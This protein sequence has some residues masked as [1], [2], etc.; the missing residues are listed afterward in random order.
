MP[1]VLYDSLNRRRRDVAVSTGR[2]VNPQRP[3]VLTWLEEIQRLGPSSRFYLTEYT[4]RPDVKDVH[5]RRTLSHLNHET[6]TGYGGA[7]LDRPSAF[8]T[9]CYALT[10]EAIYDINDASERLLKGLGRWHE[11]TPETSGSR[12]HD[13]MGSCVLHSVNLITRE[14]PDEY[15][16]IYPDEIIGRTGRFRFLV[17]FEFKGRKYDKIHLKPDGVFGIRYKRTGKARIFIMENDCNNERNETDDMSRKSHLRNNLQYDVFLGKRLY[18]QWFWEGAR[19]MLI[20]N[21]SSERKMRNVMKMTEPNA[22]T[23]NHF[24]DGFE[25]DRFRPPRPMWDYLSTLFLRTGHPPI[26]IGEP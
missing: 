3:Y 19:V 2:R 24:I 5:Q 4:K 12:V 23:L 6:K 16:F 7:L 14:M 26:T 8:R 13:F 17:P 22:Y 1:R 10:N 25:L 15:E 9:G 21:F 11:N 20:R 18:R